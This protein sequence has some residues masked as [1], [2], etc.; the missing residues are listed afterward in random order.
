MIVKNTASCWT[1]VYSNVCNGYKNMARGH[2]S[3]SKENN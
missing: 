3:F 2:W 1:A